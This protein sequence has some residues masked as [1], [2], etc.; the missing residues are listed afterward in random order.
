LAAVL[1]LL[2]TQLRVR[3]EV[4]AV[5]AHFMPHQEVLEQLV[6]VMRADPLQVTVTLVLAVGAVLVQLVV[7]ELLL[8]L[9]VLV[10][11]V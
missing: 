10:V 9:V 11:M 4:L 8:M 7:T 6:K 2:L 3:Q 5:A 1:G